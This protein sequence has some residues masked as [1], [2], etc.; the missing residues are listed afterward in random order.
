MSSGKKYD[1]VIAG[2]GIVGLATAYKIL[3]KMQSQLDERK[4]ELAS[5]KNNRDSYSA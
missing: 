5:D 1:M 3:E 4:R 2:A